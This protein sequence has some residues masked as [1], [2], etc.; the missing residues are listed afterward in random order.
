[1]SRE[2][3]GLVILRVGLALVYLWFGFS[4][5]FDSLN[6]V[7]LVPNWA[8]N[9]SHLP[10]AMIVLANGLFEV[11]VGTFLIIGFFVRP[12]TLLY[13]AHLF[14]ISVEMGISSAG[15]RDIG[16]T[17]SALALFLLYKPENRL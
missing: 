1:M 7:Y 3:W 15:V 6:W 5:L 10:P 11:I 2:D 12:M 8:V 16:L 17:L 13:V 9:L 4:Q 14:V